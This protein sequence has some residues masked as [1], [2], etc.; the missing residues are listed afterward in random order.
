MRHTLGPRSKTVLEPFGVRRA[1]WSSVIISPPALR[2]RALAV[3]VTRR[4]A[5]VIF[6][7]SSK[8]LS[9]VTVPTTTIVLSSPAFLILRAIRESETGGRLTRD[10][11]RRFRIT[12]LKG[13]S[14]RRA[15]NLYNY[16]RQSDD[17]VR[18]IYKKHRVVN[19]IITRYHKVAFS[20]ILSNAA[21]R[22]VFVEDKLSKL[23]SSTHLNDSPVIRPVSWFNSP[24]PFPP[25]YILW[26]P[27]PIGPDPDT[28]RVRAN[29]PS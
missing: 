19:T 20:Y 10:M 23:I 3:F 29:K 14:V 7:I 12:L 2:M 26:M 21:P 11:K 15:R 25:N 27:S 5:R 18:V 17:R 4:A 28:N 22:N 8:R 16:E 13:A 6:G 24:H 9:S 1:S